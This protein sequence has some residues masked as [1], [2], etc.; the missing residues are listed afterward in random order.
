MPTLV[1]PAQLMGFV[2]LVLGI[3]A[4][5][6]RDDRRLKLILV[7]ECVAYVIHFA[8]LGA[9]SA[10]SSAGVSA[11][12]TLLS[13]WFRSSWLAAAAVCVNVGLA[14]ALGTHGVGWVPVVGSSLG[15]IAVFTLSG[16]PMRVV[17]LISTGSWLA[18]NLITGSVGGTLLESLIAAASLSTIV[19]LRLGGDRLRPPGSDPGRPD[20]KKAR[21]SL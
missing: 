6:Q 4:F 7:G 10:S 8:L 2:A 11:A 17:L 1:S 15:A 14:V 16:I 18:N 19:R 13:V 12:R 20:E 21:G 5:V 3:T 9:P